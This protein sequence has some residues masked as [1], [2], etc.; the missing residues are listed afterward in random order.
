[1][2]ISGFKD[3]RKLSVWE[4]KKVKVSEAEGI[5]DREGERGCRKISKK[6]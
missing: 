4:L 1:V 5:I 6:E 3:T 2:D